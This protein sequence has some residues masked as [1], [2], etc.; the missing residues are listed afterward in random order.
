VEGGQ[1]EYRCACGGYVDPHASADE[2][3]ER[4]R[5][6]V[7]FPNGLVID[8]QEQFIM[9]DFHTTAAT[10]AKITEILEKS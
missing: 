7:G 1:V 3:E 4:I 6:V 9:R 8:G 10:L 5:V 2:E